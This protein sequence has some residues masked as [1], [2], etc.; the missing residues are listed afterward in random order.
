MGVNLGALT[1]LIV[2]LEGS[3]S[4][5]VDRHFVFLV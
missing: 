2:C 4:D 5:A 3:M 1:R